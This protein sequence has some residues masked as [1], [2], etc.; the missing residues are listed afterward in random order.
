ME[1]DPNLV[2]DKPMSGK[3]NEQLKRHTLDSNFENKPVERAL[4]ILTK[5]DDIQKLSIIQTLPQ[6]VK[7]D[8]QATFTRIVP[9]IQQELPKA[10]A[11]F[12]IT[13]SQIFRV[14]IERKV[15]INLLSAVIQGVDSKDP[16]VSS[17]WMDTL[18]AVTPYLGIETIKRDI[19]PLI[20]TKSQLSQP[21]IQRVAACRII[22]KISNHKNLNSNDIKKDILPFVHS[23]C[24]DCSVEVRAIMCVQL[25]SVAEGITA[26]FVKANL[27]PSFIELASDTSPLVREAAVLTIVNLLPF[28]EK[29]VLATTV[30]PLIRRFCEKTVPDDNTAAIISS[31][32]GRILKFLSPVLTNDNKIWF[33]NYF[34]ILS[35]KG[36]DNRPT[37]K[38]ASSALDASK[39][40]ICRENCATNLPAVAEFVRSGIPDQM[41]FLYTIFRDLAGD[42]CYIVRKAV[43]SCIHDTTKVL[44]V[45]CKTLKADIVRL[46]R[47]DAE[48]V[49][50]MLVPTL[51]NT[52]QL[53]AQNGYLSRDRTDQTTMEIGRAL[54]KCQIELSKGYNWRLLVTFL[55]Q[56]E[57]LPKCIPGDFIHQ[58]FSPMIL[59]TATNGRSKPIVYQATRTLLVFLRYNGKENQQKWM[60]DSLINQF[61]YSDNCYTRQTF[62]KICFAVLE[63]FSSKYFKE[64]FFIPLLCLASDRVSNVRYSF[65]TIFPKLK[66]ITLCPPLDPKHKILLQEAIQKLESTEKTAYV[67]NLL[68]TTLKQTANMSIATNRDFYSKDLIK[69]EE[70][71]SGSPLTATFTAGGAKPKAAAP[72]RPAGPA[73]PQGKAPPPKAGPP[74]KVGPPAQVAPSKTGP[75]IQVAASKTGPPVKVPPNQQS[76]DMSILEQHFYIDAGVVLPET[77]VPSDTETTSID[78]NIETILPHIPTTVQVHHRKSIHQPIL[79]MDTIEH[80]SIVSDNFSDVDIHMIESITPNMTDDVKVNLRK[81]GIKSANNNEMNP[82]KSKSS[83]PVLNHSNITDNNSHNSATT[84]K[85][86]KRH[87][88]VFSAA[89]LETG[90]KNLYKRHSLSFQTGECSK[91]PICTRSKNFQR[92]VLAEFLDSSVKISKDINEIE[93]KVSEIYLDKD[94]N[95]ST[96]ETNNAKDHDDNTQLICTKSSG[97]PILI[98]RRK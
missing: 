34:K 48:D 57:C 60:R 82:V 87:S 77:L 1:E 49:L 6:L 43:A 81:I 17:A 40:V 45:Q 90:S 86:N 51:S 47:D 37:A 61:C 25:P 8:Q 75:P 56:M 70:E 53:L 20:S 88:S 13:T 50:Q 97:L 18:L 28:L 26:P 16:L 19:I 84:L 39:D 80:P 33:L 5:G 78:T 72:S 74:A 89:C 59:G 66:L 44:V 24:Q 15:P 83:I 94:N 30:I 85:R 23:L 11:E 91:I 95:V 63:V 98:R 3:S 55:Q 36:F 29:D 65:L 38:T 12:Q 68:K 2:L 52:L 76:V 73:A 96:D 7:I 69:Q 92:N 32:F 31:Q 10:S 93:R 14:L 46:L 79:T 21:V 41:D 58:H 27:L 64:Y 22:G 9:K 62:V 42:P 67:S 54:L 4:F 35:R 71:A